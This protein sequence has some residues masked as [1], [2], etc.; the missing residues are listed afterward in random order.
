MYDELF[1][2]WQ[3]EIENEELGSLTSDFFSKLLDYIDFLRAENADENKKSVRSSL[4]LHELNHVNCM[5]EELISTRYNKLIKTINEKKKLPLTVLSTEEKKIFSNFLSFIKEYQI[6]RKSF[7]QGVALKTGT[8]KSSKRIVLR[9][10]KNIPALIGSDLK[11]YGPFLV[12]DVVSLPSENAELLIKQ[13]LGKLV[14][15]N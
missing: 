4:L 14:K 9:I 7:L 1:N 6:F 8:K 5:I 3:S 12:E 2:A 15:T 13:G 11:S 10:L